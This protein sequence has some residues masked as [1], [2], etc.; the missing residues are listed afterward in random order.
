M[1]L[2]ASEVHEGWFFA[3]GNEVIIEGTVNGDVYAAGGTVEVSGT[4]NGDLLVA[5]GQIVVGGTIREDVRAAGGTVRIEGNI[6]GNCT[7]AGGT[8]T[9]ASTGTI[10]DNL[11]ATGGRV[12]LSGRVAHEVLAAANDIAVAGSAGGDVRLY[13]EEITVYEGADLQKNL[14]VFVE[15]SSDVEIAAGTVKGTFSTEIIDRNAPGVGP[16]RFW[17]RTFYALMLIV[18]ALLLVLLLP[19]YVRSAG[20]MMTRETWKTVLWGVIGLIVMPIASFIVMITVIGLPV[21]LFLFFL[22]LWFLF[23]AQLSLPVLFAG[24]IGIDKGAK[25]WKLFWPV[26]VGVIIVQL[27]MAVPFVRFLLLLA[28][29]VLG[30]GVILTSIHGKLKAATKQ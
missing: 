15:D 7:A 29:L 3:S 24:Y 2:P 14:H 17:G 16:V 10:S 22:Y 27:L 21:G 11:L 30:M 8:I 28:G 6:G 13:G 20:T 18:A 1:V 19:R 4:V 23:M 5:G 9:V 26:A 12:R 25:G